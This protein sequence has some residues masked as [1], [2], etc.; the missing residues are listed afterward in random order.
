[1]RKLAIFVEGQTEAIFMVKLMEEIAGRK[2]VRIVW[3]KAS[4]GHRRIR[5]F[6]MVTG[7]EDKGQQYFVLIVDCG[8]D[9]SVTSDIRDQ[10]ERLIHSGYEAIVGIRDV[11]PD[12][13]PDD[14][15][16]L[17]RL[18][19]FGLKTKPVEVLLA[20]GIMEIETWFISEHTHFER[21]NPELTIQR[22]RDELGFDPSRDNMELRRHPAKDLNA[23]YRLVGS[24]YKKRRTCV[25]RTVDALDYEQLY[26]R[27]GKR[28]ADLQA[29]MDCIDGF[30][31]HEAC[32]DEQPAN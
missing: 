25:E 30:L 26:L 20:L 31:S 29:V 10:Y 9:S 11:Y 21:I 7:G 17:R 15:P 12:F 13:S 24:A 8:G 28:I 22:I 1:M 3:R 16:K 6:E 4:G 23:I 18:L 32:P 19:R 27:V 2:R 5:S 14:I